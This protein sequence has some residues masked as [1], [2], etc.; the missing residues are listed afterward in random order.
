M[1]KKPPVY[2]LLIAIIGSLISYI[3]NSYQSSDFSNNSDGSS[4][5]SN[6]NA[7]STELIVN[8]SGISQSEI[9]TYLEL[10]RCQFN[11]R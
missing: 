8:Q 3:P 7:T 9:R 5:G 10:P 6:A 1:Q 11:T 2:V 4:I